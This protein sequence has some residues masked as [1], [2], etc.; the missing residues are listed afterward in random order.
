MSVDPETLI[1][2]GAKAAEYADMTQGEAENRFLSIFIEA[3]PKGARVLDLG[4]GPGHSAAAMAHAG[5]SVD[6]T[7]AAPEMVAMAQAHE[8]VTA[9]HAS[10]D[11]ITGEALYDGIW[12]N[13]ALLHAPKADMPRHLAALARALKPGGRFHIGMKTGT[14]E[15]RD[16]IG[17][18]YA[19][20]TE[21]ELRSLLEDAGLTP[22][23]SWAGQERGLDGVIAPWVV[24]HADA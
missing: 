5:L 17:R 24:I 14:G 21:P 6:A 13:F 15:K 1:V 10:F 23:K 20:Y 11:E 12:A 7:D 19:Y 2:Y 9:W 3:L 4:C 18:R 16:T 22:G 8:G